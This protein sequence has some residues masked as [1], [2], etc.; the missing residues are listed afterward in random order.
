VTTQPIRPKERDAV[1][2]SLRAGVVPRAGIQLIAVD[3]SAEIAAILEDLDRVADG[4][5]AFRLII[6]AYGSGKT[7][8]MSLARAM[9]QEKKFVTLNADL[10]PDRRLHS[11][12]GQ[13]RGLYTELTS[14]LS[15]RAKPDGGAMA[16]VVER[17]VTSAMDEATATG[18]RPDEVIRRR[19]G[20]LSELPGGFDFSSVVAAYW[21]GH[22]AD[23]EQLT[24]DA[25]RWLR[26]EFATRTDGRAALGVRTIIDD[27]SVY[28][29]LKL[30][31]RFVGQAGYAGLLVTLDELVNLYKLSNTQARNANYEQILR[32]LNDSHLGTAVGLGFLLGG[33]PEFLLDTRK[34]L[35][36]YPALESRLAEN[37]FARDGLVDYS[38][39]VIRLGSLT[40]ED[41][42]VLLGKV[43]HV[44][45]GG[46]PARYRV[47]DEAFKLFMAHCERRIGEAYF[48][49]PRTTI[50]SFVNL[51]SILEQNPGADWRTVLG[52][53]L[54]EPDREPEIAPYGDEAPTG[55]TAP[56]ALGDPGAAGD[57][58]DF[59]ASF[60]IGHHPDGNG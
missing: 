47:P 37:E 17:F 54:V 29:S 19:L 56:A 5:S 33:T 46:D 58:D 3:R 16:S 35:Y 36:S 57:G 25:V 59:L 6:G 7:F 4:G 12:G 9:A 39:P 13:T 52:E 24:E 31:A 27:A 18:A 8:F 55:L 14:N 50:R 11:T 45:A 43:R 44:H 10:S 26:G 60:R 34:G 20:S 15:T 51:L 30:L 28:D 22:E 42:Y 23:D 53:T 21:R 2:Q 1:L 48:R 40:P 41:L 49:T 38:G 32:I